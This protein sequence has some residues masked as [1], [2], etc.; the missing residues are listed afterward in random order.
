MVPVLGEYLWDVGR[1]ERPVLVGESDTAV[2]LRV[3]SQA[4]LQPGHA[5]QD[6]SDVVAVEIVAELF[7]SASFEPVGFVDL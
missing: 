3:A 5:D 4:T 7:Q 1:V 2:E 6:Q